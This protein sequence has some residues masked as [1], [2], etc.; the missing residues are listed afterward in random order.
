MPI[1]INNINAI[2]DNRNFS[3]AGITTIGSGSTAIT[4]NGSTSVVNIG[5]G[6]TL[7][8]S[9]GSISISGTVFASSLNVPVQVTSFDP[10]IGST[11][12]GVSSNIILNFNQT[13]GL[14]TTG[15]FEIKTGLNTTGGTLVESIGINTARATLSN[16]GRRLSIDPTSD[17]G[18]TSSFYVTM[19]SGFVVANNNN[20][21][22]INTVGTSQTYY[23]TTK[24][25]VLG[26]S[27]GG[28]TLICQSAGVRWIVAPNAAEFSTI[29][30][31]RAAGVTCAQTVSGC[32]GWFIP[33]CGQLQNPGY[34]CRTYWNAVG[35]PYV[36]WSNQTSPG[37]N[38]AWAVRI[39]GPLGNLASQFY[40]CNPFAYFSVRAFRCV[41]Y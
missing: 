6:I 37:V 4:I 41:T 20:F 24:P 9:D 33:N 34:Q 30:A 10:A 7:S 27:F 16:G 13:V 11:A 26:D 18:F 8:G 12:V 1:Q 36:Y 19:S 5:T 3:A 21:T 39:E 31:N 17:L 14:G 15:F 32:T 38:C 22:G 25:L 23:F 2:D 40:R 35:N 29:W 28:G